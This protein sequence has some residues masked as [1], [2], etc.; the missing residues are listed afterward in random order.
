MFFFEIEVG[1]KD[2]KYIIGYRV[3]QQKSLFETENMVFVKFG[4]IVIRYSEKL[5]V[6]DFQN[7]SAE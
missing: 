6:E 2:N 4:N 5:T 1:K 7:I 3:H